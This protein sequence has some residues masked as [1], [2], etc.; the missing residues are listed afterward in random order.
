MLVNTQIVHITFKIDLITN[1]F[2]LFLLLQVAY[3]VRDAGGAPDAAG[4]GC[5]AADLGVSSRSRPSH[6]ATIA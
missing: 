4:G 5:G 1:F 2:R 6:I 3:S